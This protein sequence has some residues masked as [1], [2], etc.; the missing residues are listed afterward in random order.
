MSES[1]PNPDR[2][3]TRMARKKALVDAGIAAATRDQGL[4]LVLTGP[5]KGKSSSA[6]GMAARAL[7]H[8]LR[9]C[10]V[11]FI[12]SRTD[13][14][15]A[16]FFARQPGMDWH[17]CGEGFT[18]ETQSRARDT[19]AAQAGFAIARR[20]LAD[21]GVHLVVLDEITY[22]INYGYLELDALLAALR[23]RPP[24]QH[25]VL[26]GRDARPELIAAADTVS[27]IADLKHAFR[28]GVRAQRGVDL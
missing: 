9:V 16:G 15:E 10:V 22:L 25:V 8:A 4:V 17:T 7:G 14:G 12:K 1:Q 20:A 21:P 26:T 13:T 24:G 23:D 6:F 5:G 2:H 28:A 3:R 19:A 11:Q 27:D 18:W